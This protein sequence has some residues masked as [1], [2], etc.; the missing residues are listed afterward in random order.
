MATPILDSFT[1][2]VIK[3]T[4]VDFGVKK[5]LLPVYLT[6][7]DDSEDG[8]LIALKVHLKFNGEKY[9]APDNVSVRIRFG[10]YGGYFA[11][12]DALG[13]IGDRSTVAIPVRLQLTITYGDYYPEIEFVTEDGSTVASAPFH[14]HIVKS[15]VQHGWIANYMKNTDAFA[16]LDK[17][18]N[19][20]NEFK[21]EAEAWA[22]GTRDGKPVDEHDQSYL[23]NSKY[24]SEL[25]RGWSI[26]AEDSSERSRLYSR[27]SEAW[28]VGERDGEPVIPS[29]TC[30][31]NNSRWYAELSRKYSEYSEEN[32]K[33]ARECMQKINLIMFILKQ[34][35][36]EDK[37]EGIITQSGD[38]IITQDG[39][40]IDAV[41]QVPINSIY[42]LTQGEDRLI[43]QNGEAIM[44]SY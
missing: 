5:Y 26:N 44:A 35:V 23:N 27:L 14:V 40:V 6:Q 30:Y 9:Y 37:Q 22:R 32:N 42:L 7:Y 4:E 10:T 18:Y 33:L 19:E 12:Y 24:Y 2:A 1:S 43:T 17:I 28:A 21:L 16:Y 3:E 11:Y 25:S 8:S 39:R 29:D 13:F 20:V 36:I 31:Q 34:L 38:H 41:V 15:P